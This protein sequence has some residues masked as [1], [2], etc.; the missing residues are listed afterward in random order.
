MSYRKACPRTLD[1]PIT[2]FGLE[3]EELVAVGLAAGTLLFLWDAVPAV[4]TGAG[5]WLG[6]S[7]IKAGRPPGHLFE[8]LYRSGLLRRAP[9]WLRAPHL[10]PRHVRRLDVFPGGNDGEVRDYWSERPRLGA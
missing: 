3:P 6:L 7:R 4:V 1:R 8:L 2:V 9:A 5:L 10:V